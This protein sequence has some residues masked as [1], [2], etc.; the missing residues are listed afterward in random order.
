MVMLLGAGLG[1]VG[2]LLWQT[3]SRSGGHS[4][5]TRLAPEGVAAAQ[6]GDGW[7]VTVSPAY[8]DGNFIV[9]LDP[10]AAVVSLT[11]AGTGAEVATIQVTYNPLVLQRRSA[12]PSLPT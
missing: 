6:G 9:T 4:G 7:H 2:L 3:S 10:N 11:D 8:R 12:H 1:L 5:R